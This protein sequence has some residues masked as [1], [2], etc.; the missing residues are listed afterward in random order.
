VEKFSTDFRIP[1][2]L[3]D[4]I[5]YLSGHSL[6]EILNKELLGTKAALIKS[7][8]PNLTIVLDEISSYN[9]GMLIYMYE[10]ATGFSGYLYKIN[11]FDQ[12]AVEEGKNFTYALMGRKGY[13]E[14]LEEF[15]ELYR[16][17]YRI[18]IQ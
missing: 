17:K 9:I 12:P 2:E 11:P 16:E 3:P 15:K 7:K 6:A 14:K 18:E 13:E 10:L 8:V 1:E 5:S 4:D